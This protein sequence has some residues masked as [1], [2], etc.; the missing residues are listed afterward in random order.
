M[1]VFSHGL[2]GG[3]LFGKKNKKMFWSAVAFGVAPDMLSF[4][5]YTLLTM[6]GVLPRPD[7]S[8]GPPPESSIPTFVGSL[9]NITHSFIPFV[10]VFAIVWLIRKKPFLP[11]L[12]WPF[13]ILLDIPTHSTAF[14]PTP[15][16]WPIAHPHVHGVPWSHPYIF[17]P[18]WALIVAA[19]SIWWYTERKKVKMAK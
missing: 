1:D 2:W 8:N 15:F 11:M 14:F 12:A 3:M 9:Y 5:L 10:L 13:H 4:G 16:L 17:F 18:N 6:V 19:Y 7:W